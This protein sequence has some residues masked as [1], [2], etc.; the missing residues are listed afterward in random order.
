VR[1]NTA[2][3]VPRPKVRKLLKVAHQNDGLSRGPERRNAANGE[4]ARQA[5]ELGIGAIDILTQVL[6]HFFS[7]TRLT[8]EGNDQN[9]GDRRRS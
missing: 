9:G 5:H 6:V 3:G 2:F 8:L 1:L 7:S 4:A